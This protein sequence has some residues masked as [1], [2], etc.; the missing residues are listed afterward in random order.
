[1][2]KSKVFKKEME[3]IYLFKK[4]SDIIT[5]VKNKVLKL[6]SYTIDSE[7]SQQKFFEENF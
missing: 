6:T 2:R 3:K 4:I 1:M 5:I 7:V